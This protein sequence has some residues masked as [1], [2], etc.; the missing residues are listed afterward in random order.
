MQQLVDRQCTGYNE[1]GDL[2]GLNYHVN[3]ISRCQTVA[4]Y[5]G[6]PPSPVL[7]G[8]GFFQCC[9]WLILGHP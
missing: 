8:L 9:A 6:T 1:L 7:P 4:A 5:P 3:A 2:L